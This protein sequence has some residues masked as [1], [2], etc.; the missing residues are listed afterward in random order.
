MHVFDWRSTSTAALKRLGAH[1]DQSNPMR[2]IAS[3]VWSGILNATG[4][5]VLCNINGKQ[6]RLLNRY[7][8]FPA[9]YESAAFQIWERIVQPGSI[10]WDIG[11]N[12]GLYTI[13]AARNAGASGLVVAWEPAPATHADLRSHVHLN[14]V[15]ATCELRQEALGRENGQFSFNLQPDPS[16]NRLRGEAIRISSIEVRVRT[17]DDCLFDSAYP[18]QVIKLDIE[19]AEIDALKGGLR[20]LQNVRPMVLLAVHP[21]FVG[22][23]GYS[24]SELVALVKDAG[25]ISFSLEGREQ[26]AV[27][28]AEYLLLPAECKDEISRYIPQTEPA[29][30]C[31]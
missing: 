4:N 16:T 20:L 13:A 27:E 14:K 22:E 28:Y 12:I 3:R 17:L 29:I 15:A 18:P 2:I 7:R 21:Q 10:V 9:T 6:I 8:H 24:I 26:P 23:Y 19:G 30:L 5:S 25:Y 1:F 11:A 31:E